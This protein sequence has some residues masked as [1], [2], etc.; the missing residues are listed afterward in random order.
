MFTCKDNG[1]VFY[2]DK[3]LGRLDSHVKAYDDTK[4]YRQVAAT[5]DVGIKKSD[6]EELDRKIK[7]LA[8]RLGHLD[9]V[10]LTFAR[11][12]LDTNQN[13]EA[14]DRKLDGELEVAWNKMVKIEDELETKITKPSL[15]QELLDAE[16]YVDDYNATRR[17]YRIRAFAQKQR[18]KRKV[19]R[20]EKANEIKRKGSLIPV[21]AWTIALSITIAI[22]CM[23]I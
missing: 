8:N 23:A 17:K 3:L 13:I 5:K 20:M 6:F 11:K 19:I 21:M 16:V 2:N 15:S 12:A 14:L 22:L 1:D 9:A 18:L 7:D 10:Q 4:W